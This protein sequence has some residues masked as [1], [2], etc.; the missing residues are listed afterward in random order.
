MKHDGI[1]ELVV[2]FFLKLDGG[3]LER[4]MKLIS[5]LIAGAWEYVAVLF[6]TELIV[7]AVYFLMVYYA[8]SHH[9]ISI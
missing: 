9:C 7:S 3:F 1:N 8:N 6:Y 5:M 2:F 4:L